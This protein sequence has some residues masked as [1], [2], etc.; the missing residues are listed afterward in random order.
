[1]TLEDF[2]DVYKDKTPLEKLKLL[3]VQTDYIR[4]D[5]SSLERDKMNGNEKGAD[6]MRNEIRAKE[7][8]VQWLYDQ[9]APVLNAQEYCKDAV[10]REAALEVIEA[11]KS[12]AWS[13]SG[14]VLCGKMYSQIKDLPSFQPVP[15][16]RVMT[17]EEVQ[18]LK[19]MSDVWLD[20]FCSI[21]VA[22]TVAR[23]M[24]DDTSP[25]I[26]TYFY[27][28][29]RADYNSGDYLNIDY[30]KE[31]RCWTSRPTDEQRQAVKWE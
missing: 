28:I 6:Y 16:A 14:K 3:I 1:M 26:T 4:E 21:V 22:A 29:E 10:S 31:W 30:G 18:T 19:D 27:G 9:L 24:I 7:D 2:K 11:V 13:Q 15:V 17:L 23:A 12:V 20:E 25:D 5:V 8:R